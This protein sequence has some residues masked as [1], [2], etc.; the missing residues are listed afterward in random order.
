MRADPSQI[1]QVLLNL[2]INARD[3]M[4]DGGTLRVALST[5]SLGAA[6]AARLGGRAGE[7]LCL[8]VCDDGSG[9][10]GRVREMAFEPFFTTKE[11]EQGS[12]LGLAIVYGLMD[13]HGGFVTLESAPGEG[14]SVAAYFPTGEA[15]SAVESSET[16]AEQPRA[17]SETVLVAEDEASIREVARAALES[18]GYRVLLAADGEEALSLLERHGSEI[19]LVVT[20]LVMP[21]LG[22]AELRREAR[23]L[24]PEVRFLL[25]TG[26]AER[27]LPAAAPQKPREA[28]LLQKPW[29]VQELRARVREALDE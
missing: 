6:E 18:H 22:G 7:F 13:Q 19:D 26:Y 25:T 29:T 9:M 17:G 8:E 4:P 28:S 24:A 15:P 20:D 2:G 14:T 16:V 23:R 5:I 12:G 11:P 21:R 10:S 3:A 1:E 27:D